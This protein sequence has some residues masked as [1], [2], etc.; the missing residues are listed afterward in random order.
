MKIDNL[1][2]FFAA[3]FLSLSTCLL[4]SCSSYDSTF[5]LATL[6]AQYGSQVSFSNDGPYIIAEPASGSTGTGLIF[7]P[8]GLVSYQAYLPL[9]AKCASN[10]ISCYIIQMPDDFA[11]LNLNAAYR[12]QKRYP[13]ISSWYIAGHSLGGAMAATYVASHKNDFEGLIL[14]AAYS[15]GDIS[16]SGLK[17]LSVYGSCDGV[18]NM[19][20]YE[21]YRSNLPQEGSGFTEVVIEGGNHGQFADYGE[22][23]GDG[24]ATISRETQQDQTVSAITELIF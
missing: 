15:T 3:V 11:I 17:V 7:Y 5:D 14:L 9:M 2:K 18:L 6:K 22:Q 8:G 12:V 13:E 23:K 24:Q 16:S 4:F 20:N 10:G 1:S 21:K 19:A